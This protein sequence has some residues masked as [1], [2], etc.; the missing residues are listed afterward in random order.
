MTGALNLDVSGI[1]ESSA[2]GGSITIIGGSGW[3]VLTNLNTATSTTFILG[4]GEN[5][6]TVGAGSIS[7]VIDGLTANTGVSVGSAAYFDNIVGELNAGTNQALIDGQTSLVAAAQTASNLAGLT[8]A[9]QAVL[10]SYNGTEY[11]FIDANG[12]HVFN[13]ASD[14]IIKLIGISP[15][16]D[17]AGV[18][19][20]A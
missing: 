1:A 19:H 17:L 12:S 2:G 14:S 3:N 11:A 4:P 18:F 7:D 20:S 5:T 8:V 16:A 10:F 15:T 6:I 9:H 13:S